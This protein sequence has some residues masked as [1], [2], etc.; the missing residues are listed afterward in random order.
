MYRQVTWDQKN[1]QRRAKKFSKASAAKTIAR[2]VQLLARRKPPSQVVSRNVRRALEEVKQFTFDVANVQINAYP[3]TG[4][5]SIIA[6]LTPYQGFLQISQG[7]SA[8]QRIGN[9][10]RTVKSVLAFSCHPGIFNAVANPTPK[11]QILRVWIGRHRST[12]TFAPVPSSF[13]TFFQNN[14]SSTAPTGTI[15]D[16]IR[17]IN[18]DSFYVVWAKSYK[19]G[20]ADTATAGVTTT[21]Y[22]PNNDFHGSVN[23]RIDVT[24]WCPRDIRFNDTDNTSYTNGLYMWCE[25]VNYDGSLD[26]GTT[27]ALRMH[28]NLTY[29]YVDA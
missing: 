12:P 20:Y 10:I 26:A 3:V 27:A 2:N 28:Y 21:T 6:P 13:T 5:M 17:P 7:S 14:S 8:A 24:K 16:L 1:D 9:R 25:C 15:Q 4:T 23:E 22:Y 29:Q 19:I 11:P 18:D